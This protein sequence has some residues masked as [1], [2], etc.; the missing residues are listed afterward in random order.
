MAAKSACPTGDYYPSYCHKA[1]PTH[2]TWVKLGID[3]VRCLKQ[4][5]EFQGHRTY[6]YN[7]HPIE[8]ICL[9]GIIVSRDEQTLRTI[10]VL[11]DSTGYTIEV[12][13]S[14]AAPQNPFIP[15]TATAEAPTTTTT[16]AATHLRAAT[17]APIDISSL[18]PGVTSKLQGTITRFRGALQLHLERY[19]LLRDTNEEMH[20]WNEKNRFFVQVLS[21]PWVL[22]AE[23][24]E[25]LR[26]EEV[27]REKWKRCKR[28]VLEKREQLRAEKE[29]RDRKRIERSYEKR[30]ERAKYAKRCLEEGR[31][32]ARRTKDR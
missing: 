9:A 3:D 6:F 1:A 22:T 23:E 17:K 14:K 32:L 29:E 4:P 2:S 25:A 10:L 16:A 26:V 12:V 15:T 11:D 8:F 5:R 27:R 31:S 28:E 30:Y 19:T 13:C 20:F 21:L 7:N 18:F 24:K